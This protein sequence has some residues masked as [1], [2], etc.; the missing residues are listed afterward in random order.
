MKESLGSH[1]MF[2]HMKL[3]ADGR[4][5]LKMAGKRETMPL[6]ERPHHRRR[7]NATRKKSNLSLN[8]RTVLGKAKVCAKWIPHVLNDDQRAMRVLLATTHLRR[9][10]NQGSAFLHR[11]LT[12]T[13]HGFIH[14]TL[15]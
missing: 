10:T 15:S 12:V 14:L 6:G 13:S 4:V 5:P 11:I 9:C 3:F 7:T 1:H 2:L 8:A